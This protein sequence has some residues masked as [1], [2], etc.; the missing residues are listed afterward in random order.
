[1]LD[2]RRACAYPESMR[3]AG[4]C[5]A[6]W[7]FS[8]CAAAPAGDVAPN[9]PVAS[10]APPTASSTAVA[11]EPAPA[12]AAPAAAP[13]VETVSDLEAAREMARGLERH[14]AAEKAERAKRDQ[15]L[16]DLMNR[17]PSD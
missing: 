7:V 12:T 8:A 13:A 2:G 3:R 6:A 15:E 4:L 5:I 16:K 11:S 1:M 9:Q 14:A 10:E 17:G